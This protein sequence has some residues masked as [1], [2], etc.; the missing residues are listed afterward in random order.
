MAKVPPPTPADAKLAKEHLKATIKFNKK[1]I[2]DHEKAA[3]N[4]SNSKSKIYNRTHAKDHQKDVAEATKMLNGKY[5][6]L[7]PNSN[8]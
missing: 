7:K 5:S 6:R 3:K 2:K 8:G 1:K 4:T